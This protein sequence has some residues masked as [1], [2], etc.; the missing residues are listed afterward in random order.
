MATTTLDAF[1]RAYLHAAA[2]TEDPDPGQGEY[3]EPAIEDLDPDFVRQARDDCRRFQSE[4]WELI[5][6]DSEPTYE[7]LSHA[8][9]D[10]WY[11]RNG[12][13]CGFWDGD[14]P[15]PAATVLTDA[16]HAYG[17][18]YAEVFA[19]NMKCR[20]CGFRGDDVQDFVSTEEPGDRLCPKCG[21]EN[22]HVTSK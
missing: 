7:Q 10:F 11:T 14:W 4:C 19:G 8:G 18:V 1:T 17:E 20:T 5:D 22:C 15:E 6:P 9:R 21:G 12:Y 2:F 3:P 13:G 16:A